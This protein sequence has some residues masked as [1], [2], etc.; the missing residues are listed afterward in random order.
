[1]SLAAVDLESAEDD[2][3]HAEATQ[4]LLVTARL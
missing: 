3:S 4:V 1:M 2:V